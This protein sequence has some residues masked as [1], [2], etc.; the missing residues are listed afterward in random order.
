MKYASMSK[1]S[2]SSEGHCAWD[3]VEVV[4]EIPYAK[5]ESSTQQQSHVQTNPRIIISDLSIS[6]PLEDN[7]DVSLSDEST[8]GTS[9][10]ASCNTSTVNQCMPTEQEVS[11]YHS[12]RPPCSHKAVCKPL[13]K[14]KHKASDNSKGDYYPNTRSYDQ[15][16]CAT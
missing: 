4:V 2:V 8:E 6:S 16:P 3:L 7:D 5:N 14:L 10:Q 9:F 1:T 15:M 12:I 13:I 11:D